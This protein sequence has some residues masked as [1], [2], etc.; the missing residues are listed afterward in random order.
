MLILENIADKLNKQDGKNFYRRGVITRF[1]DQFRQADLLNIKSQSKQNKDFVYT[2]L[3]IDTHTKY[4]WV[5]TMKN[6][7]ANA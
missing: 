7:C 5:K 6:K 2:F 1:K 4:V 3:V